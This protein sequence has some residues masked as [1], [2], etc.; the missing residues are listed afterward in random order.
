MWV[1]KA[2]KTRLIQYTRPKYTLF[3]CIYHL[4]TIKIMWLTMSNTVACANEDYTFCSTLLWLPSSLV[5]DTGSRGGYIRGPR[6]LPRGCPNGL[7]VP[8]S[9]SRGSQGCLRDQS[10]SR[11]VLE[12]PADCLPGFKGIL[13]FS[14]RR[15]KKYR[16]SVQHLRKRIYHGCLS[17]CSTCLR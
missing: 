10:W 2:Q 11:G 8:P 15:F 14:Y 16:K 7:G 9:I 12:A 1:S 13:G 5:W 4:S 6:R 3:C 17:R